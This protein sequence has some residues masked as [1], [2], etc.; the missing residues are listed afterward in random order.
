MQNTG[1]EFASATKLYDV[2]EKSSI[3]KE[4]YH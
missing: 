1:K 3:I 4:M 2:V